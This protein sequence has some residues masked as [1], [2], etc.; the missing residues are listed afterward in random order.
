MRFTVY[1]ARGFIG[2]SLAAHLRG[3]GHDVRTPARDEIPGPDEP[4]GHVVYA[5]GLTGDFRSRPIDTVEAHVGALADR[6]RAASYD[7]WL[8]LSSTRVYGGLTGPVSE[9]SVL[10]ARP[11]ADGIYDLSKLL[12]E[13]ICLSMPDE[14][15]RAA[16]I[17]N[18]YGPG[19]HDN[20]FLG[21]LLADVA[22]GRDITIGEAPGSSKDYVAIDDLC[23]MIEQ[24]AVGGHHRLYNLASGSPVTHAEIAEVI[25]REMSS[26]VAFADGGPLRAFPTIDVA[27]ISG[28]ID[29][30]PASLLE[31]LPTMLARTTEVAAEPSRT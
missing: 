30:R 24:I 6:I 11:D 31:R 25:E 14:R 5:I 28:E 4:L 8:C 20:S 21:M 29:F 10:R 22:A 3:A 15:V 1:G 19:M 17:S 7:S 18:V 9:D 12:G 26:S 2:S 23:R 13:A 27:R 16:R